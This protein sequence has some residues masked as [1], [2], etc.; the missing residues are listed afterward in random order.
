MIQSKSFLLRL[1]QDLPQRRK[2][3]KY[4]VLR[5]LIVAINATYK[6]SIELL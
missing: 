2:E 5:R 4:A 6:S 1:V 3:E